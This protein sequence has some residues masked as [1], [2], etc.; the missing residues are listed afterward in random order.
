MAKE[1]YFIFYSALAVILL[2]DAK[3]AGK[4]RWREQSLSLAS[5]KGLLGFG[6]AGIMLHHMS[7]TIYFAG[8]DTGILFFMVDIGV[9]FVGIFFFF[10]GYGLYTS[11]REKPDYLKGFLFRRLTTV[12]VPFYVCNF[13]FIAGSCLWGYKLQKGELAPYAAGVVLMNSQ[14][15]YLVEIAILYVLFYLAF[16]FIKNRNAACA[17]FCISVLV[18]IGVSLLLGHDTTTPTQGLWFHGEWWYNATAMMPVG[19]LFARWEKQILS[20]VRRYYVM[21]LFVMVCLTAFFYN[22]TMY[23]LRHTG[24]WYEWEGYAGYREKAQTLAVQFPFIFFTVMT[25]IVILQKL[26]FGNRILDF[27]GSIALELYLIHNLYIL[28]LPIQ[29]RVFYIIGVYA[30]S[31]ATAWLLHKADRK[32]IESIRYYKNDIYKTDNA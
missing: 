18:M 20:F 5:S 11:L 25:V 7:Q 21:T 19:V 14:M 6:A 31:I 13:T 8:E 28:Y 22:R 3:L 24:Y 27:L 26:E 23:M 2:I 17:A 29:N 1:Y 15:W 4:G 30:A 9:C 12:L 16:R 32:L 10:S